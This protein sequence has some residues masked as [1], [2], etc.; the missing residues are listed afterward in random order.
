MVDS[1]SS[2]VKLVPV[3]VAEYVED[4]VAV[5]S[6]LSPGE[7]VVRAGVHKLFVGE[8]VRVNEEPVKGAAK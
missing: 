6:G 7:M 2:Q 4:R 3:E 5:R 1:A 8:K